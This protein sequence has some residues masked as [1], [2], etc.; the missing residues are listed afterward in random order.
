MPPLLP[1]TNR[2]QRRNLDQTQGEEVFDPICFRDGGALKGEERA[3][4]SLGDL[5]QLFREEALQRPR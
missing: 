2:R 3:P 1:E 4:L 5:M